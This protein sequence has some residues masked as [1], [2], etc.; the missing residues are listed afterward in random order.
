MWAGRSERARLVS[1][2]A[3]LFW[4]GDGSASPVWSLSGRKGETHKE[5]RREKWINESMEE[6]EDRLSPFHEAYPKQIRPK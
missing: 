2:R 3:Y 5:A 6:K 1:R 4:T